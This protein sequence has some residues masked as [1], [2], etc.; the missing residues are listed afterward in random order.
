VRPSACTLNHWASPEANKWVAKF[1][2]DPSRTVV[3]MSS[4]EPGCGVGAV[5]LGGGIWTDPDSPTLDGQCRPLALFG[6]RAKRL[7]ARRLIL[8]RLLYA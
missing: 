3:V 6:K 4:P 2:E 5:Y 1:F 8:H 7:Q